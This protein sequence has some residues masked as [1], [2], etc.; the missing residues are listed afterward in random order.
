MT[1]P[2]V[3]YLSTCRQLEIS[4]I[5]ER[6]SVPATSDVILAK[7][8]CVE[9]TQTKKYEV[10]S[11]HGLMARLCS[12]AVRAQKIR[13]YVFVGTPELFCTRIVS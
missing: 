3:P 1:S 12:I 7:T 6:Q 4:D 13:K 10:T 2:N 5:G 8:H 11:E 9:K